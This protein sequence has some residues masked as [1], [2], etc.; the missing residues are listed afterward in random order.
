MQES[1][2]NNVQS[3]RNETF[4]SRCFKS[5]GWLKFSTDQG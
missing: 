4:V 3:N 1:P 5:A 2:S